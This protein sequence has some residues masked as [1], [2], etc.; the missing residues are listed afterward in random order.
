MPCWYSEITAEEMSN[1]EAKD[2]LTAEVPEKPLLQDLRKSQDGKP[3]S[4]EQPRR[5]R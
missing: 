1:Y 2:V 4:S 5:D 3:G